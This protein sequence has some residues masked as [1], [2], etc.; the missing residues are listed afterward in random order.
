MTPVRVSNN[1]C[2]ERLDVSEKGSN[3]AF[4]QPVSNVCCL[5]LPVSN[6]Q[7]VRRQPTMAEPSDVG[8]R[9]EV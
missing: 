6:R 4:K 5:E 2:D 3:R 1:L 9:K 8:V 7:R